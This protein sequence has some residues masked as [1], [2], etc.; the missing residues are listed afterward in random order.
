MYMRDR[1][2][3]CNALLKRTK[4]F[5]HSHH[6][7]CLFVATVICDTLS[8]NK[9]MCIKQARVHTHT[10]K[11]YIHTC[12]VLHIHTVYAYK[13][14]PK[15]SKASLSPLNSS[16]SSAPSMDRDGNKKEEV[17]RKKVKVLLHDSNLGRSHHHHLHHHQ[18][19]N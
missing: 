15:R 3:A 18:D 19:V 4:T 13:K 8:V 10:Y 6:I 1:D 14:E 16:Y 17:E 9:D 5:F 7:F 2:N 11:Y 12:P